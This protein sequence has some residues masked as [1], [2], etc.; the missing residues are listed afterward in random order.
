MAGDERAVDGPGQGARATLLGL[1]RAPRP[2]ATG[3]VVAAAAAGAAVP[4]GAACAGAPLEVAAGHVRDATCGVS[5]DAA[6]AVADAVGHAA[7][8]QVGRVLAGHGARPPQLPP[9]LTI[10]DAEAEARVAVPVQAR[11]APAAAS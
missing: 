2:L 6:C 11:K 10:E 3:R 1:V 9:R 5:Q 7:P 8:R 4:E